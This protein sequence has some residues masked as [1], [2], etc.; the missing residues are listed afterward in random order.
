LS[1]RTLLLVPGL[2]CDGA[3]W[4]P[5]ID[6][7]SSTL[8]TVVVAYGR[9]DSISA[10]AEAALTAAPARFALA[11]H[12]MGG[13]VALEVM[14]RAPERVMG[15]ALLDTG[16]QPLPGGEAGAAERRQRLQWLELARTSGM[17]A[18]GQA[19]V[20]GMVHP[21][22]LRD[23][24]LIESILAM[25]S[26]HTPEAFAAQVRALLNRPDAESVLRSIRCRALV[27]CGREDSWSPVARHE[28][29]AGL[30]P[31]ARLEIV[32]NCGHMSTMERPDQ[33]SWALAAWLGELW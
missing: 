1:E 8:D 11:G 9:L 12:S 4:R 17:R 18:M 2:M 32:A 5:Q 31:A 19:W 22:R 27:L 28:A 30:I 23:A 14:R 33:V 26:R 3:V 15:L 20:R 7:L 25:I 6:A 24:A 29:M 21:D 10:M 13:R 16:Y